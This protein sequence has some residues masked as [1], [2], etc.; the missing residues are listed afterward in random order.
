M[1]PN[2]NLVPCLSRSLYRRVVR[3]R[4]KIFDPTSMRLTIRYWLGLDGCVT[5]W[6]GMPWPACHSGKSA[7]LFQKELMNE[8]T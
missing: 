8:N 7:L 6:T 1:A 4:L 3:M 5:F 2:W